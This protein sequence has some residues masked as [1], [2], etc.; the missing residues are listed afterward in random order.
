M[1]Q[2]LGRTG[3]VLGR[4]DSGLHVRPQFS[5]CTAPQKT[6]KL[7]LESGEPLACVWL[8][9]RDTPGSAEPCGSDP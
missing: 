2:S 4:G 1:P 8:H 3:E 5:P 7:W 9:P 6:I